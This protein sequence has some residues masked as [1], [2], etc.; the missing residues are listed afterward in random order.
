MIVSGLLNALVSSVNSRMS[1]AANEEE[2]KKNREFQEAMQKKQWLHAESL[3]R[4]MREMTRRNF[5]EQIEH[6]RQTADLQALE[7]RWPLPASSPRLIINEFNDYLKSG[8]PIPLQ[9]IVVENGDLSKPPLSIRSQVRNAINELNKFMSFHY[10]LNSEFAV[11]VHDTDKAGATFGSS[12]VDTIFHIFKVAP[13]MILTSRVYGSEYVLECWFWGSGIAEKPGMVEIFRCDVEELQISVLKKIAEEWKSSKVQLGVSD[14]DKDALVDLMGRIEAERLRLIQCGATPEQL[15][16]YANKPFVSEI[17]AFTNVSKSTGKTV[18]AVPFVRKINEAIEQSLLSSFKICSALLSDAHFLLEYKASPRFM[19]ICAEELRTLPDLR[20][21]AEKFF[22]DAM[23]KLPDYQR[24]GKALMHARMAIAYRNANR[25]EKALTYGLESSRQLSEMVSP[26]A[27]ALEANN[28]M[29]LCLSE[30]KSIEGVEQSVP[31]I[32]KQTSLTVSSDDLNRHAVTLYKSGKVEEAVSVWLKAVDAEHGKSI[33][34]LANVFASLH[35]HDEANALFARGIRLGDRDLFVKGHEVALWYCA[36]GKWADAFTMWRAYLQS[37]ASDFR[38]VA[39][40]YSAIIVFTSAVYDI[41]AQECAQWVQ[42]VGGD[43]TGRPIQAIAE[44]LLM[45]SVTNKNYTPV[46]RAPFYNVLS[47]WYIKSRGGDI[48]LIY[49]MKDDTELLY[50][51]PANLSRDYEKLF[52]LCK[53][54]AG[55]PDIT[56]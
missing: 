3:Q 8:K 47:V 11:K 23:K 39:E 29:Q 56:N 5:L 2:Q 25:P 31:W 49:G 53:E 21:A 41:S 24:S 22:D 14:P 33:R 9:L 55:R 50:V 6:Q 32:S 27:F 1:L 35:R 46:E 48:P 54:K 19:Q 38:H 26:D 16:E 17:Q 13:T 34:N 12:E 4:E 7:Q 52:S 30:L 40:A 36:Q 18:N 20:C 15:Q 44:D 45:S 28:E 10:G 51:L 37:S 43:T 42:V